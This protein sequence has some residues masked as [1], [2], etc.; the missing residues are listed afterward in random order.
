MRKCSQTETISLP[1]PPLTNNTALME[2]IDHGVIVGMGVKA[3]WDARNTRFELGLVCQECFLHVIYLLKLV[4]ASLESN[5]RLSEKQAY[6]MATTDLEKLLGVQEIDDD[7]V[8]LVA[9]EG[10]GLLDSSSK[11]SAIIS[12]A[13]GIVDLL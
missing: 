1:G 3:A 5:G 8:D 9:Y 2:L 6:A 13:R 7:L 10:G 11:V 4:Q 12:P